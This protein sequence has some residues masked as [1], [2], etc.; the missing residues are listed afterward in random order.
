MYR[1]ENGRRDPLRLR[2]HN[3]YMSFRRC[4]DGEKIAKVVIH[5]AITFD[6]QQELNFIE[7]KKYIPI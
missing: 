6:R 7:I 1:N 3:E 2:A 4:E 5:S